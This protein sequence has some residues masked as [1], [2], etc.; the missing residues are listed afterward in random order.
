MP[1]NVID[2]LMHLS[3]TFEAAGGIGIVV[4]AAR[5]WHETQNACAYARRIWRSRFC[6]CGRT[7]RR[8]EG[9][10]QSLTWLM[11]QALT[12]SFR[13]VFRDSTFPF[14]PALADSPRGGDCGVMK[15]I[16]PHV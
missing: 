9:V 13:L 15:G 14:K 8:G 5:S 3:R 11:V 2:L 1:T 7:L 4:S 12:P 10:H 6:R 16:I